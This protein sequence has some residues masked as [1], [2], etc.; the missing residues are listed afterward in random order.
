MAKSDLT[1]RIG[2]KYDGEGFKKLNQ[3]LK[4]SQGTVRKVTSATAGL[5]D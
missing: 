1:L 4:E 3:S 2:T 5:I